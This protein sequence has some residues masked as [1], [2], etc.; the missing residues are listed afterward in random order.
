[1]IARDREVVS[2]IIVVLHDKRIAERLGISYT[3]LRTHEGRSFQKVGLATTPP[4]ISWRDTLKSKVRDARLAHTFPET[5][6]STSAV[7]FVS[8]CECDF[9]SKPPGQ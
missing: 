7:S 2:L 6:R 8:Q 3:T 5:S 9:T 1:M 4:P